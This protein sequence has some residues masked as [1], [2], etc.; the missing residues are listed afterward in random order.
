MTGVAS[1]SNTNFDVSA[2]GAVT[3]KTG[4]ISNTNLVNSSITV[5]GT[6]GD[7]GQSLALGETLVFE[8]TTNEVNVSRSERTIT[9]GLPDDVVI[10]GNLTVNGTVVTA[11]VDNF[12]VEDPLIVLGTGN[13]ADSVDL[14]F[15]GKYTSGGV[16]FTGL[17]R[18]AGD[19]GK[20]KLFTGLQEEP[21]TTVNISGTG[22]T[23]GT[24]VARI[25]GGTF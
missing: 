8:G 6:A 2:G 4:G 15:V 9:I 16:K 5:K 11:N 22:Y 14:G 25:D 24:L 23:I 20:Y 10:T 7:A 19:N 21:T 12:T 17:F 3:V 1:F 18:D 13:G